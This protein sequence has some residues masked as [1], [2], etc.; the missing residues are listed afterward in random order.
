MTGLGWIE[1]FLFAVHVRSTVAAFWTPIVEH[2]GVGIPRLDWIIGDR[3][4]FL[5]RLT[6]WD[7]VT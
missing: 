5:S 4:K 1:P 2:G 6:A 3:S 7:T